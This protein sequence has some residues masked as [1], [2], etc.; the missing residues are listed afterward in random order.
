MT[1][2]A[3]RDDQVAWLRDFLLSDHPG[4]H[5]Q[6]LRNGDALF[7]KGT[8]VTH[9]YLIM[10]G[11]I[12]VDAIAPNGKSAL[13]EICGPRSWLDE[14]ALDSLRIHTHDAKAQADSDVIAFELGSFRDLLHAHP[15]LADTF[16]VGMAMHI[17]NMKD[18]LDDQLFNAADKR[19]ARA[20][21]ALFNGNDTIQIEATPMRFAKLIGVTRT[22]ANRV[23]DK[24]KETGILLKKDKDHYVVRR[25]P[26]IAFLSNGTSDSEKER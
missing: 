15:V 26:L 12:R 14:G 4:V 2:A 24:F 16:M 8:K 1:N 18:V 22:T 13:H 6:H 17:N 21:L 10:R 11:Q 7:R 25:A 23:V 20:L 3:L 9:V 19:L 5:V